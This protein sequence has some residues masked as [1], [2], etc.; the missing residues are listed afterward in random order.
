MSNRMDAPRPPFGFRQLMAVAIAFTLGVLAWRGGLLEQLR[1][2]RRASSILP[3]TSPN[4]KGRRLAA[5]ARIG[6]LSP[7]RTNP[8]A[9]LQN[10]HRLIDL[11]YPVFCGGGGRG[12]YIALTFDDGPG[13]YTAKT[14]SI[15]KNAGVRATF[16]LVGRNLGW[17]P[18][19]A[20]Q[21]VPTHVVGDHTWN[22]LYL[23]RVPEAQQI[24]E[25]ERTQ[26]AIAEAT[27]GQVVIFRPP[28]G[29]RNAAVDRLVNGF[30]MLEI[31][32]SVDSSDSFPG[33]TTEQVLHNVIKGLSP[34]AIILMHE[35]RGTTLQ[36]L[37]AFLREIARRG[38]VPVT[39]PELLRLDPPSTEQLRKNVEVGE[40]VAHA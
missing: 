22:H 36:M 7:A 2:A 16:F 1:G 9:D 34:G 35:N 21:E 26:Q 17:H 40:C 31:M 32:W 30:G 29:Y 23:T 39:V 14:L 11:G 24:Q 38:F 3:T 6:P 4:V 25:I 5:S 15:L 27:L 19:L 10:V 33:V 20:E 37:P 18:G 12:R 13:P 28:G 8:G